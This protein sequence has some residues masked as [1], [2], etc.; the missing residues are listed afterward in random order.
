MFLYNYGL[1]CFESYLKMRFNDVG[2]Q[3]IIQ[4]GE[5]LNFYDLLDHRTNVLHDY[6][7][8]GYLPYPIT[9]FHRFFSGSTT[10]E[11][12]VEYPKVDYEVNGMLYI[13]A[14]KHICSFI[15]F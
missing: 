8:F 3:K 11:H 12:R 14:V 2:C 13:F 9:N 6:S 7:F 4:M 5:W 1:G 10:Q 15:A